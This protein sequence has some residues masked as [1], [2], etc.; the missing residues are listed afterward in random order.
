LNE[1]IEIIKGWPG[2]VQGALGS[3]LFWLILLLGKELSAKATLYFSKKGKA[4][5]IGWLISRD[6]KHEAFGG[7]NDYARAAYATS[8]LIYRSLRHAYMGFMWLGLGCIAYTVADIGLAIG[9]VGLVYYFLKAYDVVSPF[10]EE[11]N[12]PEEWK[13]V[14]QELVE[15][16]ILPSEQE[17]AETNNALNK[18]KIK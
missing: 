14:H 8:C 17:E 16:Q 9:G 6:C 1:I 12:T 4:R 15:L 7:T 11:E 2:I 13:K 18:D 5:R 3:G 10:G